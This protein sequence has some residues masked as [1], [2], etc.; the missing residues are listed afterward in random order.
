MRWSDDARYV[1]AGRR[2]GDG[3]GPNGP[4]SGHA[5]SATD[6]RGEATVFTDEKRA[7]LAAWASDY[8]AVDTRPALRQLPSTPAP[9]SIDDVQSALKALPRR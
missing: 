9:V 8:Y 4:A 3:D 5:A 1:A 6:R 7:I 2:Q